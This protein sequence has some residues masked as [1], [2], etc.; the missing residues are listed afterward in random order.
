MEILSEIRHFIRRRN[1]LA[2]IGIWF[3]AGLL[4]TVST[5]VFKG[6]LIGIIYLTFFLTFL[7]T[8]QTSYRLWAKTIK[9]YSII[10]IIYSTSIAA[11]IFAYQFYS[12]SFIKLLSL[13]VL[14]DIGLIIT[15]PKNISSFAGCIIS[16]SIALLTVIY[17]FIFHDDFHRF[18]YLATEDDISLST[19]LT[20]NNLGV[21]SISINDSTFI[22][23]SCSSS[24]PC[25]TNVQQDAIQT[26]SLDGPPSLQPV[27]ASRN[28]VRPE[29]S[30]SSKRLDWIKLIKNILECIWRIIESHYFKVV[31]FM[32]FRLAIVDIGLIN[33][34]FL[35]IVI[36]ALIYPSIQYSCCVTAS[37]LISFIIINRNLYH[38]K[39]HLIP[40]PLDSPTKCPLIPM[41]NRTWAQY[42]GLNETTPN[43]NVVALDPNGSSDINGTYPIYV[44]HK[45]R[46]GEHLLVILLITFLSFISI[47]KTRRLDKEYERS[48]GIIFSGIGRREADT[49][50]VNAIKYLCNFGFYQFGIEMTCFTFIICVINRLDGI[51]AL[52]GIILI[53]ISITTSRRTLANIWKVVS[54]FV[55]LLILTQYLLILGIPE[56]L[57][58]DYPWSK[59]SDV[60]KRWLFLPDYNITVDRLYE[61]SSK[62]LYDFLLL[63]AISRQSWVFRYT[64]TTCAQSRRTEDAQFRDR[65]L[66]NRDG[67]TIEDYFTNPTTPIKFL[68]RTF[69][70][71]FYWITLTAL[72][73]AGATKISLFSLG[74]LFGCFLFL[75][76][77]NDVY[78]LP[79]PRLIFGWNVFILYS[80]VVILVKVFLQLV[81]CQYEKYFDED[82]KTLQLLHVYC[83]D[84]TSNNTNETCKQ[85]LEGLDLSWDM[86]CMMFL[87]MQRVVF[88]SRY[89]KFLSMEVKAQQIL[90]SRGAELIMATQVDEA[91]AQ[92]KYEDKMMKS[93]RSKMEDLK[94]EGEEI[95]KAWQRLLSLPHHHQIIRNA[96]RHLFSTKLDDSVTDCG[97]D[98]SKYRKDFIPDPTGDELERIDELSGISVVFTRWMKGE[99]PFL[100]VTKLPTSQPTSRENRSPKSPQSPIS[101]R[102][103]SSLAGSESDQVLVRPLGSSDELNQLGTQKPSTS[104]DIVTISDADYEPAVSSAGE[105]IPEFKSSDLLDVLSDSETPDS[106]PDSKRGFLW[107]IN[108]LI[109]SCLLSATVKLNKLSRSYRY[110]SRRMDF[111]KEILK[112]SRYDLNDERF[113]KDQSW[114][115]NVINSLSQTYTPTTPD[116]KLNMF[117]QFCR[118]LIY[119]GISNTALW[120]QIIIIFNQVVSTSLLSLPLA[121]LT[122]LWGTLSV[123]RPTKRFWKTV[124]AI[125]EVVI[126]IKY[127]CQFPTWGFVSNENP[128]SWINLLGINAKGGGST[129]VI[130]LILLLALFFHR[131]RLKSLG[132]WNATTE[133]VSSLKFH[134]DPNIQES[135][136]RND[137]NN[138]EGDTQSN[139]SHNN[140]IINRDDYQLL[141]QSL[142]ANFGPQTDTETH[143]STRSNHSDEINPTQNYNQYLQESYHH[144]RPDMVSNI[145]GEE[146]DTIRNLTDA[147]TKKNNLIVVIYYRVLRS[148]SMFFEHVLYTPHP[149]PND[150]YTWMFICDFINF[151]ILIYG[152]WAFGAGYSNQS[153][154][155][156][157]SENKIP[158]SVLVMIFIQFLSI[159]IDRYLYL[160]K[161]IKLKL[162]YQVFL[163][164]GIHIW[165][166]F[167]LPT[168]TGRTL[169]FKQNWPPK[170][171]Y[172]FKSIYFL[173]SAYQIRSG[174]PRRVL[175]YCFTKVFGY[176]N[177]YFIKLY[178]AIPLLYDLR[179]YMDWMITETTLEYR[180][181]YI[182]EDMFINLFIRKCELT[183]E[184][185][186]PTPRAKPQS[187]ISKYLYGGFFMLLILGI[188]WG[189]LILFST[190][191]SV[192]ESNPPLE[193]EYQLEIVG[194]EPILKMRA[195]T[196]Q[197][198]TINDKQYSALKQASSSACQA[199]FGDYKTND[200]RI[201]GLDTNSNS[202]W[203]ISPPSREQLIA[204]LNSNNSAITVKSSF[205][206]YREKKQKA[207]SPDSISGVIQKSL[208]NWTALAEI[209]QAP[210]QTKGIDTPSIFPNFIRVPEVGSI[211]LLDCFRQGD[212][213]NT[214]KLDL[215]Y[216]R[217]GPNELVTWWQA[218]NAYTPGTKGEDPFI[219][220]NWNEF[221]NIAKDQ[222]DALFIVAFND[223][224]FTGI[225]AVLSGFGIIGLYTTFVI[226]VARV[227][228][229]EPSGKVIY[230]ELPNVDRIY[231]LVMDIYMMRESGEFELEEKLFAKLLFLYRCPELLIEWSKR[232]DGHETLTSPS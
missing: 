34:P 230:T 146:S 75:L 193:F 210:N 168:F 187:N 19:P 57:C 171:F 90:A 62:L 169:T 46:V 101:P 209:L 173:L 85:S 158:S 141:H 58:I 174:Y 79:T 156:F 92:E 184:G 157:L 2:H 88:S 114:R 53:L 203:S 135:Q 124:I 227:I 179:I 6:Q 225:L 196:S 218:R 21:Q 91:K 130:D 145:N 110:V 153:V 147:A 100:D 112:R 24:S 152:F 219:F 126:V 151:I 69:F 201:I 84:T 51:A 175:G 212:F 23:L 54:L 122:L 42:I 226:F 127:V 134:Q 148:V 229:N 172:I 87:L 115:K 170:L 140:K 8:F 186:Y 95:N 108:N 70:V 177:L 104:Q 66:P 68:K 45:P 215:S 99:S 29:K 214:R 60:L 192:G 197:I 44:D 199:F 144:N 160:K 161:D 176:A 128:F 180:N 72:L 216:N 195:S 76:F 55:S 86:I 121:L 81:T 97:F 7:L 123:P 155:S 202:L 133:F 163:V 232:E 132:Q 208:S 117:T 41:L 154:T 14:E 4:L 182:M 118:A 80:S 113:K 198:Y 185:E 162:G 178:R 164:I 28:D 183:L 43:E 17:L 221:E 40:Y 205:T 61:K 32:L 35:L 36:V 74:Y 73:I 211:S 59:L 129:I 67:F 5:T 83:Y 231:G 64:I 18:L 10:L 165:L 27:G 213:S 228:R 50:I 63:L 3:I 94:S 188:V 220:W 223:R 116:I 111:E 9:I 143:I 139:H 20:G 107:L 224:I 222:L 206:L 167:L 106:D 96:D 30:S 120:C 52:Y 207:N 39:N 15:N 38:L 11:I 138:L 77:G 82:C 65:Y 103:P 189:P 159:M 190:G 181:W 204:K 191:K 149:T 31:A 49:S 119:V 166:F 56:P 125:T 47:H 13:Q 12:D 109:F 194:F 71:S 33:M 105:P 150:V 1:L 22:R 142:P 16:V 102:S 37:W 98:D 48:F 131:S 78:L 89:F 26:T 137:V 136:S 217:S 93:I 200:V 25:E